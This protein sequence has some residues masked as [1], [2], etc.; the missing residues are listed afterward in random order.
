MYSYVLDES[1]S[2]NKQAHFNMSTDVPHLNLKK[3][4]KIKNIYS[5]LV[6]SRL[7]HNRT[8]RSEI[9]AHKLLGEAEA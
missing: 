3:Y 8:K 9:I 6:A 5:S 7:D 2:L 1:M 4:K